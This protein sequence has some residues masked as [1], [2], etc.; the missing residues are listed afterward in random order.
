MLAHVAGEKTRRP[1]F[2]RIPKVHGLATGE[3]HNPCEKAM[4][5][6]CD[7]FDAK[8]IEFQSL[9]ATVRHVLTKPK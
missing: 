2:V 6:G 1:Q 8:P 3:V 4:D 5:T 9:L 7:E